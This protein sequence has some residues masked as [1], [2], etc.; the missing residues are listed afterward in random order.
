MTER[1]IGE[2]RKSVRCEA[3]SACAEVARFTEGVGLRNSTRP[4]L[5]LM[6]SM[7][8]FEDFIAGVKAGEFD[9]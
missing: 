6:F 1:S 9:R 7:R 5:S 8:A 4:D 3:A 2:W